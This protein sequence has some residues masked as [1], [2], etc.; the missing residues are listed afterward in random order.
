MIFRNLIFYLLPI[1]I[2][3]NLIINHKNKIIFFKKKE[4]K[5]TVFNLNI[6]IFIILLIF[7]LFKIY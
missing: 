4:S 1:L 6:I 3:D 7:I 2:E 5:N